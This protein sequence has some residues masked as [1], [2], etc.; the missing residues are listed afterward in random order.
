MHGINPSNLRTILSV[1]LS[2]KVVISFVCLEFLMHALRRH[3]I[4][5]NN[6]SSYHRYFYS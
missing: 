2:V 5:R 4:A 1:I 6:S 3:V